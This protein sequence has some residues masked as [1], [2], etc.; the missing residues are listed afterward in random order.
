MSPAKKRYQS[1][2][3]NIIVWRQVAEAQRHVFL[4][5]QLLGVEGQ[6]K[7]VNGSCHI[8]AR[9]LLDLTTLL[10]G[11]DAHSQDFH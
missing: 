8:V 7:Q 4:E 11:L 2:M 6:W 1:A 5:S 3:V 10:N 9:K